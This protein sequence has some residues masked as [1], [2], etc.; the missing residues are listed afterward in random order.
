[1]IFS[2]FGD[3]TNQFSLGRQVNQQGI[4]QCKIWGSGVVVMTNKLNF[5]VVSDF[6]EPRPIA[7]NCP[8]LNAEPSS[9]AIIEPRFSP[10][11]QVQVLVATQVQF[12]HVLIHISMY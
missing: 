2:I 12:F 11:R 8:P 6:E 7:M 3:L 9:W 5:F 10:T 1:M 4:Y